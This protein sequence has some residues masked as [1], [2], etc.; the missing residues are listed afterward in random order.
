MNVSSL[1]KLSYVC[2]L[3]FYRIV[4]DGEK[5]EVWRLTVENA[6]TVLKSEE[7]DREQNIYKDVSSSQ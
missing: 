1:Q 4:T 7:K 5:K 3:W 2:G 6:S